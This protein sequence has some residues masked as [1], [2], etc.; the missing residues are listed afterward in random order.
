MRPEASTIGKW[1]ASM[2]A[3]RD[4][5][6]GNDDIGR[7]VDQVS[8]DLAGLSVAVPSHTPGHDTIQAAG[9]NQKRHVEIHLKTN[10]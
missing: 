8:E 3:H 2:K 7:H 10:R 9:Q 1:G 4:F 5:V 6:V